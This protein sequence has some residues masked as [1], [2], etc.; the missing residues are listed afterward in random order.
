MPEM[1]LQQLQAHFAGRPCPRVEVALGESESVLPAML[2]RADADLAVFGAGQV[3]EGL[4]RPSLSN[5][6]DN[7][8]CPAICMDGAAADFRQ[9]TF[10]RERSLEAGPGTFREERPA[11]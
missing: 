5:V 4:W 9:W 10:Q 1:A 11:A 8:P 2:S 6:I 7:L 3:L